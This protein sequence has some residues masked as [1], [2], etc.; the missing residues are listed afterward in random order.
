MPEI[1]ELL[2]RFENILGGKRLQ[3]QKISQLIK[4]ITGINIDTESITFNA[5]VLSIKA[6]P[7]IK[8]E[9]LLKKEEILISLRNNVVGI[10]ISDI[11]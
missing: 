2:A 10:N 1:S 11:R 9:L 5:G 8:N 4:D 6:K 3:K 7:I